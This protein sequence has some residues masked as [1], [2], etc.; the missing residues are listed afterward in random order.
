V[1]EDFSAECPKITGLY[2]QVMDRAEFQLERL[3]LSFFEYLNSY[4]GNQSRAILIESKDRL[5]AAGLMLRTA[6]VCTF[7]LAG[8]D[9]E[10]NRRYH[11]YLNLVIEV[12]AEAIRSGASRLIF[13][14]TSYALKQR[15]G[16]EVTP[17]YLYLRCMS[18]WSNALLRA[19]ARFIFPA[20]SPE[21]R[22]VFKQPERD[23]ENAR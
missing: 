8:I 4:L 6:H 22:I 2:N 9:Y 13:G 10:L 23:V 18:G 20:H 19:T 7:L 12:V 11:A 16:G 17:L 15:M 3:G 5:L 21:P 14:Q 1:I